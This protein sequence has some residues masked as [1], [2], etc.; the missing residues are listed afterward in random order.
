M[1]KLLTTAAL[2][3]CLLTVAACQVSDAPLPSQEHQNNGTYIGAP[4]DFAP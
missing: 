2:M 1:T 4:G 3:A